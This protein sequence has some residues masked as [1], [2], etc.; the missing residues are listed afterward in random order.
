MDVGTKWQKVN[1]WRS[2]VCKTVDIRYRRSARRM[3][4]YCDSP[5]KRSAD[6]S[7]ELELCSNTREV[8]NAR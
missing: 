6:N 8:K 3:D 7:S 4:R 2:G 5:G 1:I